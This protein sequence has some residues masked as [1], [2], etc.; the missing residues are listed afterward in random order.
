MR[1]RHI[2]VSVV[3][4]VTA[5]TVASPTAGS[6]QVLDPCRADA[7]VSPPGDGGPVVF[8]TASYSCTNKWP[9]ISVIGCLLLDGAPVF[10][11][12]DAQFDSSS[13]STDLSAP[14]VPGVWTAVAIGL[15]AGRAL[16]APDVD[17][18]EVVLD[19]D[20]LGPEQEPPP[21]SAP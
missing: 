15:G 13:A 12:G 10:C 1:K 7:T 16:P 5:A 9:A 20:P 17:T 4:L 14:C 2:R 6:A 18:P 8:G 21:T 11:N 19:C 3:A